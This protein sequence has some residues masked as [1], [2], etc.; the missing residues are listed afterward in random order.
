[1]GHGI[2]GKDLVPF[3]TEMP[4]YEEKNFDED[5]FML[6]FEPESFLDIPEDEIEIEADFSN[7]EH[8]VL[9]GWR[10]ADVSEF[11]QKRRMLAPEWEK[12]DFRVWL[13][14]ESQYNNVGEYEI[15]VCANNEE[16]I[17]EF[18]T[19]F[20]TMFPKPVKIIQDKICI[21]WG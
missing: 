19:D 1:M 7:R 13:L 17:R 3:A 2:I 10:L 16:S 18:L 14:N 5:A 12:G 15:T 20:A 8:P 6:L 11:G 9:N 4:I 21:R